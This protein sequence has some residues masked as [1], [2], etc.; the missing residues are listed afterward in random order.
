[1]GSGV[2]P[3]SR[4][5]E[6]VLSRPVSELRVI[7]ENEVREPGSYATVALVRVS[8]EELRRRGIEL[9]TPIDDGTCDEAGPI[10]EAIIETP[11]G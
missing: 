7:A 10:Q 11:T 3:E 2:V 4:A 6:D 9:T 5:V 1:M 8:R